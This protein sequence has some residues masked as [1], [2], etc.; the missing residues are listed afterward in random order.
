MAISKCGGCGSFS[1][2]MVEKSNIIGSRFKLMFVQCA[3]C[4]VPIAVTE[5]L[6]TGAEIQK[7]ENKIKA[8]EST[9]SNIDYNIVALANT[10]KRR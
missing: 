5:Y 1:F 10:I 2:E 7:L 8:L 4:G 6:N 9:I 3:S